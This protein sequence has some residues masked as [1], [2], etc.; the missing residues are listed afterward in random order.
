MIR[1]KAVGEARAVAML[2]KQKLTITLPS[3]LSILTRIS[4]THRLSK[5]LCV[6]GGEGRVSDQTQ[7]PTLVQLALVLTYKGI[8][9]ST[10]MLVKRIFI[11]YIMLMGLQIR[12]SRVLKIIVYMVFVFQ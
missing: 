2:S 4:K 10:L 8:V 3:T 11:L 7:P 5:L 12:L 1:K 6:W 9:S